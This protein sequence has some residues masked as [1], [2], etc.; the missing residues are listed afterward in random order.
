MNQVI[1]VNPALAEDERGEI[2][3]ALVEDVNHTL[4]L[5]DIRGDDIVRVHLA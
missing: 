1:E 5:C 3:R 2:L 4:A